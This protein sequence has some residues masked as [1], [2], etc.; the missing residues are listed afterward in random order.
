MQGVE[1][2]RF[3]VLLCM[4]NIVQPSIESLQL[5]HLVGLATDDVLATYAELV[6]IVEHRRTPWKLVAHEFSQ[7]PNCAAWL[8]HVCELLADTALQVWPNWSQADTRDANHDRRWQQFASR[9]AQR[10][11]RPHSAKLSRSYQLRRLS[12][13]LAAESLAIALLVPAQDVD[14]E[15]LLGLAKGAEWLAREANACVLLVVDTSLAN[16][17]ALDSLTFESWNQHANCNGCALATDRQF[18]GTEP[19]TI[20]RSADQVGSTISEHVSNQRT[21]PKL[22]EDKLVHPFLGRPHPGSPGE[23][24]LHAALEAD[25]QLAGLF[26]CNQHLDTV[27]GSSPVADLVWPKGRIVVEV[28]GYRFH[29]NQVSFRKD[30]QRDYELL[31]SGYLVLR[32]PHDVVIQDPLLAMEKIRDVVDYRIAQNNYQQ[33]DINNSEDYAHAH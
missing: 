17:S 8:Q 19:T 29:S 15:R 10:G 4:P 1:I 16:R 13:A 6:T 3:H 9:L 32:L 26:Q 2:R 7:V 11:Q 14:D 20:A 33:A 27:R 31:I 28:D 25:A 18:A 5:Q 22:D 12:A 21:H 30:R 24:Q 23:Q